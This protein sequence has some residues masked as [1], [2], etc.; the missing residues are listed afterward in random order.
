MNVKLVPMDKGHLPAVLA[1]EQACFSQPWSE[2]IFITELD[3]DTVSLIV[4]EN[5]Y[6]ALLG[7]AELRVIL[8]E[9]TLE[10]IVVAPSARKQGVAKQLLSAFLRF[11]EKNLAFITLEVRES[12]APA[13]ALYGGL[14]FQEV[15]RRKNYYAEL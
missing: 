7:Y 10:K 14:G 12:N 15:G 9:G 6:G 5:D 13:I 2:H 11:G 8:D 3:S 4:A 1:L